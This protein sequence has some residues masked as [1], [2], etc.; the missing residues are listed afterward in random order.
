MYPMTCH[1]GFNVP[2]K[3][4]KFDIIG[5]TA[6]AEDATADV[7]VVIIDDPNINQSGQVGFLIDLADVN[8]PTI[9]RYIIAHEKIYAGD[10]VVKEGDAGSYDSTI[11]WF[12]PESIKIR[13]GTSLAFS[14]IKQG[15][16]CL[17]VR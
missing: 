16:F 6:T 17:Y 12:P 5:F 1:G 14:N 2:A 7:E 13:Y 8:P 3:S 4:G 10:W 11:K 9:V 15:S